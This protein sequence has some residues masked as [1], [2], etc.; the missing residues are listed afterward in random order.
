MDRRHQNRAIR[1]ADAWA[2]ARR[3]AEL[4]CLGWTFQRIADAQWVCPDHHPTADPECGRCGRMY[5]TSIAASRSIQKTLAREYGTDSA[6]VAAMRD[7]LAGQIELLLRAKLPEA[8]GGSNQAALVCCRLF[9]R[10]AALFG[11]DAPVQA[12]ITVSTEQDR[13]IEALVAELV[14]TPLALPA[15][16]SGAPQM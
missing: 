9:D 14:G 6:T 16:P 12:K 11:L 10:K 13:E 8:L 5:S 2:R 3:A 15:A 4:R 1:N 7:V